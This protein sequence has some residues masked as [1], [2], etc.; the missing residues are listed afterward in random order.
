MGVWQATQRRP[1]IY[2]SSAEN[3]EAD[4]ARMQFSRIWPEVFELRQETRDMN[5]LTFQDGAESVLLY[6]RRV[7]LQPAFAVDYRFEETLEVKSIRWRQVKGTAVVFVAGHYIEV[8]VVFLWDTFKT[9]ALNPQ[10]V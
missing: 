3:R 1:L 10:L 4:A 2:A 8:D 7:Y 9:R 5:M 6:G